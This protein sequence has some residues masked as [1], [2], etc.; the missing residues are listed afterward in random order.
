MK[1]SCG[2]ALAGML[3]ALAPAVAP[4]QTFPSKALRII[5]PAAPGGTADL[6]ARILAQKLPETLGQSV[7]VEN[8]AGAGG[9]IGSETLVKSPP[10]GHTLILGNIG[11]NAINYSLYP[12]LPYEARDFAPVALVLSVPNVLVVPAGSSPTS[13]AQLVALAKAKPG[14]VSFASSGTGQSI[15]LSGELFKL[16]TGLDI[17]HIPYKGA[18]PAVAD[19]V[20][21]QVAMM[22]DNIPSSMPHIRS[23]KLRALAVTSAARLEQL[24][25]VPTMIESG[26]PGFEV[27]AWFGVLAPAKTPEAVVQ[28]LNAEIVRVYTQPD[29]R[30]RLRGLAATASGMSPAQFGDFIRAETDKW[31]KV[32]RAAN[33]KAE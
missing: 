31:S 10:D 5:V 29:V 20:A 4:A 2:L 28:R 3:A 26:F 1:H 32:V 19:L 15:H 33:L 16:S 21:G 25:E 8:R 9:I 12:R 6:S 27:T 18:G 22:F 11:P 14:Q 7:V 17:V 30:E 13:V 24:A 23:G